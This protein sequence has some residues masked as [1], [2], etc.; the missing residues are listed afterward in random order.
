MAQIENMTAASHGAEVIDD[1][2]DFCTQR[3]FWSEKRHGIKIALK[4]DTVVDLP[5]YP[6]KARSP[7]EPHGIATRCCDFF[8]P[9]RAAL[10]KDDHG[11]T[12][13]IHFSY[14]ALHDLAGVC[15]GELL[16]SAV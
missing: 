14:K 15:Q 12:L 1:F 7:V 11:D 3:C 9:Q 16:K 10:G 13:P 2:P 8:R 5:P 4:S 6:S